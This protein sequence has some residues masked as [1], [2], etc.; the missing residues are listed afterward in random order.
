M[1]DE[2]IGRW[3]LEASD[4]FEEFLEALG[5]NFILRKAAR[6]VTP[7]IIIAK[8]DDDKVGY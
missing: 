6:V 5:C 2:L 3:R 4:N 8:E 1:V 7:D